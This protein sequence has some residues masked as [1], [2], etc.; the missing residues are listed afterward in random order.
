MDQ[1][2]SAVAESC[3]YGIPAM[4]SIDPANISGLVETTALA[5][6]MDPELAAEIG[7]ET[8]KEYRAAGVTA[9]L[10]PRLTLPALP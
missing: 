5:S 1:P 7:V 4:I 10:G 8:S 9:L 3:Y 6:T 2:D